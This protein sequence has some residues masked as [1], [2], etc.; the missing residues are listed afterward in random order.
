[1]S[2]R[3]ACAFTVG[4]LLSG[5]SMMPFGNSSEEP[6]AE[7]P[8]RAGTSYETIHTVE[9]EPAPRPI[10]DAEPAFAPS[11][12]ASS[13]SASAAAPRRPATGFEEEKRTLGN[14]PRRPMAESR[15]GAA[16]PFAGSAAPTISAEP[17]AKPFTGT[18]A[19]QPQHDGTPVA[20]MA[21]RVGVMVLI[22]NELRHVHAGTIG[23][24]E[25]DFNVQYDFSGYVAEEL[26]KALVSKTPY[27]P[28]TVAPTG[29]LRRDAAKW[30]GTWNGQTFGLDYQREFDGIIKQNR[31]DMLIVAGY[32]TM[33]D[34]QLIG[35]RKLFGSG[36]YTRSGFGS[37]KSAVFSTLQFYRMVG[38]P[39][40]LVQPIA[41]AGERSIGDLP[42][43]Q[44]PK[45]LDDLPARY[46]V[47]VYEPLR[48]LVQNKIHG[49]V[50]LPRKLGN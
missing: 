39:A 42:N 48:T 5:C 2:L 38:T 28:V 14:D 9:A 36:L 12:P 40:K 35:G 33:G 32:A 43:A 34:G 49:L 10:S 30:P 8:V 13:T 20:P 11:A 41:P 47:P 29:L 19:W 21:G 25:K 4:V 46:L 22:G 50:S 17:A 3:A 44:L 1:M 7:R 45:D 24:S 6:K 23:G 16:D 18:P 37:T 31:L 27:Q 15:V 26:R